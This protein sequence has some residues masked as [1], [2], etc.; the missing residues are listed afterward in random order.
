MPWK[1]SPF[2]VEAQELVGHLAH[3]A[4]DAGLGAREGAAAQLV[5]LGGGALATHVLA[6]L[7]EAPH[8]EVE[9]VAASVFDRDEVDRVAPGDRLVDEPLIAANAVLGM[10]DVVAR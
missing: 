9:L 8:R 7:V 10:H 3:L 6:E 5:E 1:R 4:G 2:G